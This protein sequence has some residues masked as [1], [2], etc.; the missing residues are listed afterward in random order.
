MPRFE[1]VWEVVVGDLAPAG[2]ASSRH[3]AREQADSP[4]LASVGEVVV[5]PLG[6]VSLEC[7]EGDHRRLENLR[8]SLRGDEGAGRVLDTTEPI[9]A[10][11]SVEPPTG[12]NR[13]RECSG[14][15]T[16]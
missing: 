2:R 13:D 12:R 4:A 10:A 7:P 1:L 14:R 11:F 9:E 3:P 16:G 8:Q 5:L 6:D 15:G